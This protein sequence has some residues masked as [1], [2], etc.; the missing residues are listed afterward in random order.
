[1][2]AVTGTRNIKIKR[3]K[4]VFIYISVHGELGNG[5]KSSLNF[6]FLLY[7]YTLNIIIS[8]LY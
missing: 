7:I 1:M 4:T 5:D 8:N 2:T 3:N 6:S